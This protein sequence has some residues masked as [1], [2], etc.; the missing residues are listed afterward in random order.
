MLKESNDVLV[1]GDDLAKA[2]SAAQADGHV[3]WL[4][5][6]KFAPLISDAKAAIEGADKVATEF[7]NAT[8]E[9]LVEFAEHAL[10]TAL[11]LVAAVVN[12]VKK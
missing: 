5:L 8:R 6:P 9:E 12:P 2:W 10:K 4:D 7:A 1:L 3:D 11:A